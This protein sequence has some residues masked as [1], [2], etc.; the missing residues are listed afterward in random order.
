MAFVSCVTIPAAGHTEFATST[1]GDDLD[2]P[3]A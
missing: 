3:G 1:A 2:V